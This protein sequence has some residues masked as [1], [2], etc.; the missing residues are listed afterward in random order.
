MDGKQMNK[1]AEK[2]LILLKD[3]IDIVYK[4]HSKI[5]EKKGVECSIVAL[6]YAEMYQMLYGS[7]YSDLD[8]NLE[9]NKDGYD[10]K[11]AQG[12]PKGM[13]PDMILHRMDSQ[14]NNKMVVEFKGWWSRENRERDLN[15]LSVLT[16]RFDR[17]NYL[18]G[19]FVLLGEKKA[20]YT[21]IINGEDCTKDFNNLI[22]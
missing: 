17:Y 11:T 1:E 16:T 8:L 3:A 18:L 20:K 22:A 5:F 14:D 13:C 2:L 7:D 15:K 9:Y 12:F 6:I 10:K 21:I 4:K 19:V